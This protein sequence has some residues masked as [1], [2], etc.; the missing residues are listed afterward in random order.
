MVL[1]GKTFRELVGGIKFIEENKVTKPVVGDLEN[2]RQVA[3]EL[4]VLARSS[5]EDKFIL[6]TGL[7]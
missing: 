2:F 6:V 4:R 7:K 5:P 1:E 3:N